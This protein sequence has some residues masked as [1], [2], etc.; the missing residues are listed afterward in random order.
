MDFEQVSDVYKV[1]QFEQDK[2]VSASRT[3]YSQVTLVLY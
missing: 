3:G 2:A 1:F